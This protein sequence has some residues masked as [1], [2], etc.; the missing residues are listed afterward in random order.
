MRIKSIVVFKVDLPIVGTGYRLSGGRRFSKVEST[1]VVLETDSGLTGIGE[2]CPLGGAYMPAFAAG[3]R[4]GLGELAPA[5]IGHNPLELTRINEI[6][7]RTLSGHPYIKSAIDIA[8]WDLLG[9]ATKQ[10]V[11]ALMGGRLVDEIPFRIG[12]PIDDEELATAKLMRLRNSG[13]FLFNLKVGDSPGDDIKRIRAV[14]D[15]LGVDETLVVD[16]NR[17]WRVDEALWVMRSIPQEVQ[18]YFEQ[19]CATYEENLAVRKATTHSIIFDEGADDVDSILR[20]HQDGAA[21]AIT[22]KIAR[23][24]GLTKARFMRDLCV[25]LRIPM[26]IQDPW[27]SSVVTAAVAHLAHSTPERFLLGA[28]GGSQDVPL[29]TASNAPVL[30]RG[31]LSASDRPGLGVEPRF[32]VLGKPVAIYS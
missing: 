26:H 11:Y 13:F 22:F 28:W 8:C 14:V 10:P 15:I 7:D 32:E 5:L 25:A 20:I 18:I 23:F 31:R 24:G 12:L 17:G 3:L 30:N 19:P 2:S 16:A 21:Q 27:G 9:R 29:E 4:A 1:F 6:M